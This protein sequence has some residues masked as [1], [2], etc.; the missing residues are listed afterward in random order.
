MDVEKLSSEEAYALID[1]IPSDTES[2]TS[3][4]PSEDDIEDFEEEEL[5][6]TPGIHHNEANKSVVEATIEGSPT[7]K[8]IWTNNENFA[9]QTIPFT[10]NFGPCIPEEIES[11]LDTFLCLFPE[12]LLETIVFQTNLYATQKYG[13]RV[14]PT[15]VEEMKCFLGINL[16]MG[17]TKKPSYKDYWSSIFQ[18]RDQF[19]SSVMSR[20][21]FSWILGNIHINNN[22][23][24]PKKR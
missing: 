1:E 19:I 14:L 23:I 17:L 5:H 24:Q 9:T 11:P 18:V 10:E 2:V 7:E 22:A 16:M 8:F 20:D 3:G 6:D 4:A 21:R 15:N 13:E 12:E